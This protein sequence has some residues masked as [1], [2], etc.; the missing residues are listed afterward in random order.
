MVIE[1]AYVVAAC[2]SKYAKEPLVALDRYQAIRRDPYRPSC[3]KRTRTAGARSAQSLRTRMLL[4]LW[5]ASGAS[6]L[7][8]RMDWLYPTMPPPLK[9]KVLS[10]M[11]GPWQVLSSLR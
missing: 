3:A 4:T 11:L 1:D 8:E 10:M 7:R 2:L 6:A 5:R 9:Y